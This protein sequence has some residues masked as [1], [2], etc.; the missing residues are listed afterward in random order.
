[1][2]YRF[3]KRVWEVCYQEPGSAKPV[4]RKKLI[5]RGFSLFFI[6]T[7]EKR[8]EI[9]IFLLFLVILAMICHFIS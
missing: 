4:E 2:L 7:C 1:M 5:G 9:A 3:D 8:Y 6:P